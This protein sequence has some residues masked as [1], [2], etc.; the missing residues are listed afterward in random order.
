MET[1]LLCAPFRNQS[2]NEVNTHTHT[3]AYIYTYIHKYRRI[4]VLTEL[5]IKILLL[6]KK[7]RKLH[8]EYLRNTYIIEIIDIIILQIPR[9]L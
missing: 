7:R 3:H 1:L 2:E 4:I 9:L 8:R 5:F 6:K